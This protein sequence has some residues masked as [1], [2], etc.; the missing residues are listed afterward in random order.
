MTI[1]GGASFDG[2]LPRDPAADRKPAARWLCFPNLSL[3]VVP[4]IDKDPWIVAQAQRMPGRIVLLG[5][6]TALLGLLGANLLIAPLAAASA[7][8]GRYRWQVIPFATLL[9]LWRSGFLVDSGLVARVAGQEGIADHVSQPL[10]LLG[11]TAAVFLL[12]A[13]L[14][15]F[16]ARIVA[17]APFRWPALCLSVAFV[18]LMLAAESPMSAGIHRVLLWSFLVTLLPYLWFLAYAL[19]EVAA[20]EPPPVLQQLGVFH[21]FWGSTVTPFGKSVTYLRKFEARTDEELAVTQ[22]KG[23]KLAAWVVLLGACLGGLKTLVHGHLGVP[24]F[25]DAFLQFLAG[26][27][28]SRAF[29]HLSLLAY[30]A[31]D[32]LAMSVWGG[33]IVACARMAGFRLLRNT[34]R[35]LEATTLIEFWNRYYFYYKELLV[36]HFFYPTFLRCFRTHRKLRMFFATFA[37]ACLGNLLFHFIRDIRFVAELGLWNAL[38]GE[39]SHAFYTFV[40]AIGLGLSQM[41]GRPARARRGWLR[42]RVLPC[43]GVVAFFCALHVFDAPLDREHSILQRGQFFL[44]LLGLGT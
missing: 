15:M 18:G 43:A 2:P 27:A 12:C 17:F 31:E 36:D 41:R 3:R 21:P 10:I 9:L 35:P 34:Y 26:S 38:A 8:S 37:A 33:V 32:V 11:S 14:L 42:G 16:Y 20:R 19:G 28:F 7:Y 1:E 25:D 5:V 29:C 30:F 40:L 4:E 13:G 44:Y 23:V 39:A 6:F 22:L 24:A